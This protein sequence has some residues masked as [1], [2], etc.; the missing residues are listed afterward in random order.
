MIWHTMSDEMVCFCST[1][2]K[3]KGRQRM[4]YF[5]VNQTAKTGKSMGIWREVRT[6]LKD[7]HVPYKAFRTQYAGH[8]RLLAKKISSLPD[9]D[10]RIVVLG[11]D[12]TMNEVINGIVD[13]E[14]VKV[15]LIPAG[16]GNDFAKGAKITTDVEQ[17]LRN[18][19]FN[20][21]VYACDLG[22]VSYEGCEKP[23]YF[24]ISAGYGFDAIVCK[25]T[26][27][28]KLKMKLNKFGLGK[29]AYILITIKTL[30]S[31][32]TCR[33]TVK[34][35]GRSTVGYNQLVFSASMNAKAEGGGVPM[36][37]KAK[38]NDGKLS[39]CT[40]HDIP[41]WRTFFVLPFLIIGKHEKFRCFSIKEY[42]SM[43]VSLSKPMTLHADGEFLADT[44]KMRF[45]CMPGVL[46]IIK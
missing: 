19:I 43:Y 30:L 7:W 45:E 15:G 38:M 27:E 22:L 23:H 42:E 6:Y 37:P 26:N 36:T 34:L 3:Y 46:R 29:M 8:A 10:I 18:I 1:K 32:R 24:A 16:S 20:E 44:K 17:N 14:R 5:I 33:A 11:G 12:G 13:F 41:V 35:D 4:L 25:L 21:N 39:L 40:V 31:M 28:S 9:D 2:D